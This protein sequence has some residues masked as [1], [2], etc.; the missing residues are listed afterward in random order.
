[1]AH[2]LAAWVP[3]HHRGSC[4]RLQPSDRMRV[5]RGTG[6]AGA[7]TRPFRPRCSGQEAPAARGSDREPLDTCA[8]VHK[9]SGASQSI[10]T[11]R[12]ANMVTA[13]TRRHLAV[14]AVSSLMAVGLAA[15]G[16]DEGSGGSDDPIRIGTSLPLTGEFSQPG[17]AARE[18][19]EIWRDM[20]NESG[21]LLGRPVELVVKDDA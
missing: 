18:G 11:P 20:V 9:T 21:G 12:R 8:R 17:Q 6:P 1:M 15:C 5:R 4:K 16:G 10:A 7:P 13:A 19:Y 2:L 14:A 3:F